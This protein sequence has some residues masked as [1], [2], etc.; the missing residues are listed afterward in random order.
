M[1]KE[2]S[3]GNLSAIPGASGTQMA[4]HNAEF[5]TFVRENLDGLLRTAYLISWDAKE[6]TCRLT[7][8]CTEQRLPPPN[9]TD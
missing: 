9:P 3:R 4:R 8:A 7:G 1:A 2:H 6:C 5:D